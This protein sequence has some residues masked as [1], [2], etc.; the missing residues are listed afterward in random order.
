MECRLFME[1]YE[2]ISIFLI[3]GRLREIRE[4]ATGGSTVATSK[5]WIYTN[6]LGANMGQ[7]SPN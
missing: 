1:L 3:I 7:K 4:E 6:L 5:S 2:K